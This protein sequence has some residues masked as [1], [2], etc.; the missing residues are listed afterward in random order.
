MNKLEKR[1]EYERN[2]FQS[3]EKYIIDRKIRTFLK[4]VIRK[5][6][7]KSKYE[8]ILGYTISQFESHI[9]KQFEPW[10]SWENYGEWEIDHIQPKNLFYYDSFNNPTLR[11]CWNLLNLRPLDKVI[12]NKRKRKVS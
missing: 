12:N 7:R 4:D 3:D 9:E 5:N 1:R 8:K 10:M 6:I 2:K 11:K